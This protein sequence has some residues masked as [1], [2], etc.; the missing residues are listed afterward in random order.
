MILVLYTTEYRGG[1]DQLERAARTLTADKSRP[2][3]PARCERVESKRDFVEAVQKVGGAGDVIDELH[4]VG[5][6]GMYGPMF[7]TREFPE[8][9][10]PHEWRELEIPFARGPETETG[11]AFF[12]ACR[13]ARWFAPFF[14]RTF[15]VPAHGYHWY[16]SFSARPDRYVWPGFADSDYAGGPLYLVGCP[17]KKSHGLPASLAKYTGV[18]EI[19]QMKRFEPGSGAEKAEVEGG[20]AQPPGGYDEVAELYDAVFDDIRVRGDEWTWLS[21]HVP[22]TDVDGTARPSVLDIGCGN[23]ALLAELSD[24]I[25]AGRGVD[26]SEQMI[27]LARRRAQERE[28]GHLA[29]QTVDGPKLPF[30]DASFDVVTSFLSFRYLDWD[31]ILGE[32]V[33]VLKPGGRLLIVDMVTKGLELDEVPEFL[34]SKWRVR[35]T[36]RAFP[37]FRANLER[38]I[39]HP[40]WEEMLN[41]NPIRSE[42]EFKWYLESRFPGREVDLV[43]VGW[44]NRVLAFDSG[45]IPEQRGDF[46]PQSYP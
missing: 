31:P 43:N 35:Q 33:R 34:A 6:S 5:H 14:A 20:E 26:I 15:D 42:H 1:G 10:S 36:A 38:L 24:R 18:V 19:E 2:V 9:F 16:T 29:F 45:P 25:A 40:G 41:H 46:A 22:Q 27:G 37:D 21:E 30:E 23:G 11:E 8:Q 28:L 32:V 44:K 17:G 7:G 4:F 3:A 12:H 13:T 39:E